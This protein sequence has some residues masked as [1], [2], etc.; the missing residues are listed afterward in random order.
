[1]FYNHFY[2]FRNLNYH[3]PE[4][5]PATEIDANGLGGGKLIGLHMKKIEELTLYFLDLHDENVT[6]QERVKVFKHKSKRRTK[7]NYILV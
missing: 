4:M 6:L 7:T 3:L 1:M 2:A 5:P